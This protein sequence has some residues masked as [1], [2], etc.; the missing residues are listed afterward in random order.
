MSGKPAL[1]TAAVNLKLIMN[2][3]IFVP[4][5]IT[6][7]F[8]INA[9]NTYAQSWRSGQLPLVFKSLLT[10]CYEPPLR[11]KANKV[12]ARYCIL[13][14]NDETL[15]IVIAGAPL[16]AGVLAMFLISGFGVRTTG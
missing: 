15:L 12:T 8:G 11:A 2:Q 4:L 7:P 6:K 13:F 3:A 9:V 10:G 5:K 1:P 16:L 14:S